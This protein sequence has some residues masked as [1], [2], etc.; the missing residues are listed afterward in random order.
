MGN[1]QRCAGRVLGCRCAAGETCLLSTT[2]SPLPPRPPADRLQKAYAREHGRF[3]HDYNE[4]LLNGLVLVSLCGIL[5]FRFV[6][7]LQLGETLAWVAFVFLQVYPK[8][9]IGD[10]SMYDAGWWMVLVQCWEVVVY[11]PVMDL[12]RWGLPLGIFLLAAVLLRRWWLR[13]LKGWWRRRYLRRPAAK[14]STDS[15]RDLNV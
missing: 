14:Q 10:G 15:G 5:C 9:Y 7:R 12:G 11:N 4:R 2:G 1:P 3:A 6:I 13:P 8:T